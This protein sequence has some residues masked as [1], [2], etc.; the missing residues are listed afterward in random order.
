M[1]RESALPAILISPDRELAAAAQ[2]AIAEAKVFEIVSE[3]R[4]YPPP[5]TAEIRIRQAQPDVVL[6][7][8]AS[9]REAAQGL[10]RTIAAMR[11]PLP[12]VGL[13]MTNDASLILDGLRA[14]AGDFLHA[15]FQQVAQQEAAVR[16]RRLRQAEEPPQREQGQLIAFSATKPGS[17][18]STLAMQS[19]FALRRLTGKRVLLVDFDLISGSVAFSLKLAPVYS[20]LDCLAQSDR[21]NPA[22]WSSFVS[23]CHGIDILAA[24]DSP[25]TDVP[26]SSRVHE[27][28]EYARMFY[29]WVLVDLPT[30]FHQLSLFMMS[31]A[32]QV[33]LVSTPEL[34]SLHLGRRASGMLAQL[35]FEKERVRMVVNRLSKKEEI[36]PAD[37]EKIFTCPVYS[38]F[39][40]DYFALHKVVTRAE[41]LGT[42][43]ELGKALERFGAKAANLA[44][45]ERKGGRTLLGSKPAL[46]ES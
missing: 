25:T 43:T 18:S 15:P 9:D 20:V 33:Y 23:N 35:G 37:M 17:G 16:I 42:E 41:P 10:L 3:L 28:I 38:A 40:N 5:Q 22:L 29:D 46:S 30:V 8:L 2:R 45:A 6:I 7:D 24:P 44:A 14:G 21:L 11:P 4:S 36:A 1:S 26:E 32:D 27:V 31:E 13:G 39:P 12:A 19:A 34:A